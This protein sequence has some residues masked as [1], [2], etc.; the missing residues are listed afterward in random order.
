MIAVVDTN[1]LLIANNQH[2]D[3]SPECIE[4]CVRRLQSLQ[5]R[6]IVVIDD[7]YR[8]LG[9]YAQKTSTSPPKGVGDV[10]LK[11]LLRNAG[12]SRRVHVVPI[13]EGAARDE[14]EE[15][16]DP[17]LQSQFDPS[18]RKFAA[19]AN[20]HPDKPPVWQGA[21]SKWLD[22]W[23]CLQNYGVVVEFLCPADACRFYRRKFPGLPVPPLPEGRRE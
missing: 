21:D 12:N 4:E 8:I 9:E 18:D 3:V 16:P 13:T 10:F 22:W 23:R 14:F 11:W 20:A 1:V 15:F 17:A 5:A 7:D 2:D 19:V 6:G